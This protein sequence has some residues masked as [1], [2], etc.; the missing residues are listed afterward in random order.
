MSI[1]FALRSLRR[2]W[3]GSTAI[4]VATGFSAAV[5]AALFA[6]VDG[7]VLRPL[8]F[9]GSD[10]LVAIGY[11]LGPGG[12]PPD[13]AFR[14]ALASQRQSLRFRLLQSPLLSATA[15]AGLAPAF[16]DTEAARDAALEVAGVDSRF[17]E[18]LGLR[19]EVGTEFTADDERNPAAA[20]QESTLPLPV[21]LGHQLAA[22]L[23]GA[24][25]AALGTHD[26]AGRRVRVVGV[27][28]VGFKFPGETNVWAPVPA[29]R[30]QLPAY[31]RLRPGITAAAVARQFPDLDVR[32]LREAVKA[33]NPQALEV[34]FVASLLLLVLT[35]AQVSAL[36]LTGALTETH[37]MGVMLAL[38]ATRWKLVR[39]AI[40]QNALL[41]AAGF[42]VAAALVPYASAFII[43]SIPPGI[44]RGQ[45]LTPNARTLAFGGLLALADFA[46]IAILP[47][48]VAARATPL[49]VLSGRLGGHRLGI[50]RGRRALLTI[51]MAATAFL[52]YL[53]G[54]TLHSFVRATTFDYGFD[55]QG[56]LLFTVPANWAPRNA[57]PQVLLA[58]FNRSNQKVADAIRALQSLPGVSGTTGFFRGPLDT[59]LVLQ[60]DKAV[61]VT[62]FDGRARPD[63]VAVVDDVGPEF[64][65]VFRVRVLAGGVNS[66]DAEE[67]RVMVNRALA[68]ELVG[69]TSAAGPAWASV[70]GRD[71]RTGIGGGTVVAVIENLVLGPPGEPVVGELFEIRSQTSAF[72]VIA[73]RATPQSLA[74]VRATLENFW[75][76]LST[77]QLEWMSDA[78]QRAMTPY[79]SQALLLG[80]IAAAGIPIAALGLIGAL[81]DAVRVRTQEIAVRVVVGASRASI[82][83]TVLQ[84]ALG[85]VAIGLGIGAA[86]GAGVG[87]ILRTELF[88]V[89]PLDALT[90]LAVVFGM[91]SLAAVAAITPA[92]RA[93]RVDPSVLLRSV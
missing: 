42:L 89:Q 3:P 41:V 28:P 53:S 9:P 5:T 88:H 85:P 68:E 6:V 36:T 46:L 18:L 90:V 52:L 63:V 10:R 45:Y 69:S 15:Q 73:T 4:V 60:F 74:S 81:L 71:L 20:S 47:A 40:A 67:K 25:T 14:P 49:G 83:G 91:V 79:R 11:R 72:S 75:G 38:G 1:G 51:Q 87:E 77:S 30:D 8:P 19:A 56:L 13:L 22:T 76:R 82:G 65:E 29:S 93:A 70:V 66:G 64:A 7:L 58:S 32:P 92:L 33:G 84:Q 43:Q 17:F 23:F 12:R 31:A 48:F 55:P 2:R 26:L 27:M 61:P 35:W 80:L 50:E 34:L 37:D 78:W 86:A 62:S 24:S 39:L 59:G 21:I 16:F 57:T 54:L 44:R